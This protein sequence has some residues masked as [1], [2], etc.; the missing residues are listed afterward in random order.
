MCVTTVAPSLTKVSIMEISSPVVY[1]DVAILIPFP[2]EKSK[3]W[4]D[5]PIFQGSV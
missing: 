2:T 4:I 5:S 1:V 3:I